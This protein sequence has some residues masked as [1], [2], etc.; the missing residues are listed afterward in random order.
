MYISTYGIP[1]PR[2][3]RDEGDQPSD[4]R[5]RITNQSRNYTD[6]TRSYV[7]VVR[8]NVIKQTQS[9]T[10]APHKLDRK[11]QSHLKKLNE[12]LTEMF[13]ELV[14]VKTDVN[15]VSRCISDLHSRQ[16]RVKKH[17]KLISSDYQENGTPYGE[18]AIPLRNTE[19]E[20]YNSDIE[21]TQMNT[22]NHQDLINLE[23]PKDEAS[24]N[25]VQQTIN[26]R[27]STIERE[28]QAVKKLADVFGQSWDADDTDNEQ[29]T[30][31]EPHSTLQ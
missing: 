15:I 28:L 22:D 12:L 27:L 3:I 31:A 6:L 1:R 29:D 2:F 20:V 17:L 18:L 4:T 9:T 23:P 8:P 30:E 21:D 7:N 14:I 13:N 10:P 11:V 25:K 16:L 26:N 19:Q 5:F 24:I